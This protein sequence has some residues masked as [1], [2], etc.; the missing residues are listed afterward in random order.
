MLSDMAATV[1][2]V[3]DEASWKLPASWRAK[4]ESLRAQGDTERI[5]PDPDAPKTLAELLDQHARHRGNYVRHFSYDTVHARFLAGTR[6]AGQE[7]FADSTVAYLAAPS[8]YPSAVGAAAVATMIEV[9]D[10]PCCPSKG[11]RRHSDHWLREIAGLFVDS[12]ILDHGLLFAV[13]ATVQLRRMTFRQWYRQVPGGHAIFEGVLLQHPDRGSWHQEQWLEG[14]ATRVRAYLCAAP[15]SEY[16]VV[17]ERL[18]DL[19]TDPSLMIRLVGSYLVPARQDWLEADISALEEL[20]RPDQPDIQHTKLASLEPVYLLVA[21]AT[22]MDQLDRIAAVARRIIDVKRAHTSH[23]PFFSQRPLYSMVTT[24]GPDCAPMIATMIDD[25]MLGKDLKVLAG[26]LAQFPTDA[27]YQIL[28]DRIDDKYVAAALSKATD[29][30]PQ[31]AVRLLTDQAARTSS[32]AVQHALRLHEANLSGDSGKEPSTRSPRLPQ[33]CAPSLLPPLRLRDGGTMSESAVASLVTTLVTAGPDGVGMSVD[34]ADPASLAEV[35]WAIFEAWQL[36]RY[37]ADSRWVLHALGVLGDDDTARKLTPLILEWPTQSAYQRALHGLD[38]LSA[39][40]TDIALVQLRS[41]ARAAKPKLRKAANGRVTE[42]AARGGLTDAQLADRMV[43]RLGLSVNCTRIVDYGPRQFVIGLDEHLRASITGDGIRLKSLPKP[44]SNDDPRLAPHAYDAF[45]IFNKEL[46]AVVAEQVQRCETALV[47]G[48]RWSAPE[49]QRTFVDHPILRQIARRLI[50]ATFDPEGAVT[51]SFRIDDDRTCADVNDE[52]LH[53]PD[54]ALVGLAHPL[55]LAADLPKWRDLFEDYEILQPFDQL[56]RSVHT[57]T[58]SEAASTTLT[59]FSGWSVPA[60]KLF[61]MKSRGW[62]PASDLYLR[63][64]QTHTVV[65]RLDPGFHGYER[66]D[67]RIIGVELTTPAHPSAT[68]STFG[69][70]DAIT[71]SELLRQLEKLS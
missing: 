13:E 65:I 4:A 54:D 34:A 58:G 10:G 67:Q 59:R 61:G 6:D 12:W 27:A 9:Y 66:D 11:K 30:F 49:Y 17:V 70:L 51:G 24:F 19:R 44:N 5:E 63:A 57:L 1:T 39:I 37:P 52:T 38:A 62:T 68:A 48:R 69:A 42:L 46:K 60:G 45:T 56:E 29:R 26:V 15:E 40:G 64:D 36:A 41:V 14:I 21:S 55:H 22:T 28:L 47:E 18:S 23:Y 71:A 33:W 25:C 35:A 16:Q 7:E 31:R 53:V 8:E 32:P 2:T 20:L 3:K 50:W 43:P